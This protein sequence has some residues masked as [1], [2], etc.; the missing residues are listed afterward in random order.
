MDYKLLMQSA[1][2]HFQDEPIPE[3]VLHEDCAVRVTDAI[4]AWLPREQLHFTG[5]MMITIGEIP[6]CAQHSFRIKAGSNNWTR[7]AVD[8]RG[9]LHMKV[10]NRPAVVIL[11]GQ[12]RKLNPPPHIDSFLDEMSKHS[13]PCAVP[14]CK[15]STRHIACNRNMME[16][17]TNVGF[18]GMTLEVGSFTA[19]VGKI[20]RTALLR[21]AEELLSDRRNGK[22]PGGL[23][24]WDQLLPAE[25]RA[26]PPTELPAEPPAGA[27]VEPPAEPPAGASA[28]VGA[29]RQCWEDLIEQI[30]KLR[31]AIATKDNGRINYARVILDWTL[32]QVKL[33]HTNTKTKIPAKQNAAVLDMLRA[34]RGL[35]E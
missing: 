25:P 4:W 24:G 18:N 31:E 19:A 9:N 13:P 15:N 3:W 2:D 28:E 5:S 26:E 22:M 12:G 34:L 11:L 27:S 6:V 30:N 16:A 20:M 33:T 17:F 29:V 1:I 10:R 8:S 23:V 21:R 14:G 7:F 35:P 32:E